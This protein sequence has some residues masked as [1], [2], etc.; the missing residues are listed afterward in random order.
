MNER[1]QPAQFQEATKDA[2]NY[3]H[4]TPA[5]WEQT[6][7]EKVCPHC[8][9]RVYVSAAPNHSAIKKSA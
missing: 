1:H 4:N 8:G 6:G 7:N 9:T 5:S 3:C 2:C